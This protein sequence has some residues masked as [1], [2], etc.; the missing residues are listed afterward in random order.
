MLLSIAGTR[1][2]PAV[3]R[4]ERQR[5]EP[6]ADGRG[7]ARA[8]AAGYQILADRISGNAVRRAHADEAGCELVEIGLADDDG[9]GGAQA[10][11]RGG[12]VR[13]RVGE[14]RAGRRGRKTQR[15]DIVLHR[16]RHAVE[17]QARG[18]RA[19]GELLGFGDGVLF[20]TQADEHGGIVM[21]ADA[22]IGSRERL[23]RRERAGAVRGH[24]RGDRF[25][26]LSPHFSPHGDKTPATCPHPV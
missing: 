16:D 9:A 22:L 21:V 19:R 5:H 15:V 12:V 26:L 20:V 8:G 18:I 4:T 2:D 7:R 1:P 6:C 24:N 25:R 23:C 3:V 10:L 13:R 11:H 14:G 17:R